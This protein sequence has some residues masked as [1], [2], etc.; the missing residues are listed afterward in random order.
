MTIQVRNPDGRVSNS[1]TATQP[2]ILEVPFKYDQHNLSFGNFTD[3]AP[4]WGTFE[5][6][7][8]SAEVWHELLDPIF[9]HRC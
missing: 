6:T 5:D 9:G 1:R 8:G 4:D 2:R 7:F 3:G